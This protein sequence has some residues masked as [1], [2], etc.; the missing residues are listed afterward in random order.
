MG[1]LHSLAI[2][3]AAILLL[4]LIYLIVTASCGFAIIKRGYFLILEQSK[5]G[6]DNTFVT[7]EIFVRA[8]TAGFGNIS[9]NVDNYYVILIYAI[10]FL[11]SVALFIYGLSISQGIVKGI[12]IGIFISHIIPVWSIAQVGRLDKLCRLA[13]KNTTE[14]HKKNSRQ[15]VPRDVILIQLCVQNLPNTACTRL[16]GVC[17]FLG[18]LRGWR[19]VPSKRRR[20]VP[21]TSG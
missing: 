19:L 6:K 15:V 13:M 4:N 9:W 21:P 12:I 1:S 14:T 2:T 7:W 18:V 17:A 11:L 16:V 3:I 20:L 8:S 5:Y 10:S